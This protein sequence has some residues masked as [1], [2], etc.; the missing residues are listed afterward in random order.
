MPMTCDLGAV[1][2]RLGA[3]FRTVY[4]TWVAYGEL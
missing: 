3:Y 4:R 1:E 2:T